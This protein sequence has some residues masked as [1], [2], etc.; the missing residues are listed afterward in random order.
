MEKVRLYNHL[1]Y[2]EIINNSLNMLT[3]HDGQLAVQR[4]YGKYIDDLQLLAKTLSVY[5]RRNQEF[6]LDKAQ[7]QQTCDDFKAR[8]QSTWVK[9][10]ENPHNELEPKPTKRFGQAVLEAAGPFITMRRQELY[11][12]RDAWLET[13]DKLSKEMTT[14]LN[15]QTTNA[16][17]IDITNQR[18]DIQ[19]GY[20]VIY[21]VKNARLDE[22]KYTCTIFGTS[23]TTRLFNMK[24]YAPEKKRTLFGRIADSQD[25]QQLLNNLETASKF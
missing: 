9:A 20:F 13:G 5:D 3:D 2:A 11:G 8:D 21:T 22:A 7:Y 1:T 17:W 18:Y 23:E 12:L 24:Y 6:E 14:Y 15:K 10:P 19:E 4:L 16:K 25:W